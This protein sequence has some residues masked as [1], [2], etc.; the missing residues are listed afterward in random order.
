MER[1]PTVSTTYTLSAI[2]RPCKA[3]LTAEQ[4]FPIIGTFCTGLA[5][6]TVVTQ[7]F[8]QVQVPKG[9]PFLK[10]CDALHGGIDDKYTE[11]VDTTY[12]LFVLSR[13]CGWDIHIGIV[14][15]PGERVWW[16]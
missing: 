10:H 5:P 16:M 4:S 15:I 9:K 12:L 11:L 8:I 13:G 6:T 3:I 14:V 1:Q 2:K 7:E